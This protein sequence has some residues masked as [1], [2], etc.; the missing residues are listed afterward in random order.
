MRRSKLLLCFLLCACMAAAQRRPSNDWLTFGR[1]VQRTGWDTAEDSLSPSTVKGLK[2]EWKIKLDNEP[3]ELNSLTPPVVVEKAI[4]PHGFKDLIIVGGSSDNLYAIDADTGKVFW[5]RH[6]TASTPAPKRSHWL[7]PNA[8]ETTPVVDKKSRTVY[9]ISRDGNVRALNYIN[10]ED[11][12]PPTPFVPPYAKDW[13]LSLVDGV[14]YTAT[15]QHCSGVDNGV[16]AMN[17]E[18]P[19]RP[20]K[21][22]KAVG[23]IWGRGGVAFGLDGRIFAELGD[24]PFDVETNKFSDAVVGLSPKTLDLADY[25]VPENQKWIDKKDLDMGNMTPAVFR[26]K[27]WELV[28]ASGKEG[29]IYLLDAK[30]LGGKDHRTPLYRSPLLTNQDVDFAGRGFWGAFATWE[31][32]NGV[33]WLYA[34][35]NGPA[36]SGAPAFPLKHGHAPNGSVMAFKVEEK[37]GKPTLTPAWT[38]VDMAVPDPPIVANGVVYA[39]ST[40]EN[41]RQVPSSGD[42][43][44]TSEQRASTPTGNAILYA[45]DAQTGE[46]LYSSGKTMPAF[47]HFSGLALSSGRVYVVTYDSTLYAFSLGQQ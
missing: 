7:C 44:L 26:Y 3:L 37:D 13:S 36:A 19:S 22:W 14:L 8:L 28:A 11:R 29:V 25:Y 23:G 34:P 27:Q 20:V 45:L 9:V 21:H 4:T 12:F 47:T 35:A 6:F 33:R 40:G 41:T 1:D 17:L 24:G 32:V 10:G 2:L 43:L 39:V 18:D 30:S 15:S 38:S 16:W 46:T 42:G 5:S 31:D